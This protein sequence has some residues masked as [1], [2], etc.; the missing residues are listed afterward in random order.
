MPL[1]ESDPPT[2]LALVIVFLAIVVVFV[3]AAFVILG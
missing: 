2:M 1:R 3:V